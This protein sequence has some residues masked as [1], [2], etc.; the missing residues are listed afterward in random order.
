L[1][2]A[3]QYFPQ[4]SADQFR[5]EMSRFSQNRIDFLA[6]KLNVSFAEAA[7]MCGRKGARLKRERAA[8]SSQTA[9][10]RPPRLPWWQ[11]E[12]LE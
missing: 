3:I 7:A 12:A 5:C 4:D 2:K 9:P 10:A 11:R 6:K 8:A 1:G